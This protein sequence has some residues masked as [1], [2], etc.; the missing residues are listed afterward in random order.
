MKTTSTGP[1]FGVAHF[2]IQV[3]DAGVDT[4]PA[5]G[6]GVRRNHRLLPL[7][8]GRTTKAPARASPATHCGLRNVDCGFPHERA[9]RSLW[10][11]IRNQRP[12]HAAAMF[13]SGLG[14]WTPEDQVAHYAFAEPGK[15][16][17]MSKTV[18]ESS[19]RPRTVPGATPSGK[20]PLSMAIS[21]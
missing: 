9:N 13:P 8:R 2:N 21:P 11:R 6:T 12:C 20:S 10:P 17:R 4:S 19:E 3:D 5:E 18:V 1:Y 16:L 7:A 15:S 14:L